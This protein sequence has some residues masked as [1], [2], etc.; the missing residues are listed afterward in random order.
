VSAAAAVTVELPGALRP[1]AGGSAE[2]RLEGRHTTVAEVLRALAE[3]HVGVTE[4]VLDEQGALRPHVNLFVDGENVRWAE[5]L[6]TR[7]GPSST[8]AIVPAISGG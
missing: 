6:D 7:V 8:I 4:R 3:R 1:F 2:L 5:G